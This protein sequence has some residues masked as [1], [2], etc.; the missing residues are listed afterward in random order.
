MTF[1]VRLCQIINDHNSNVAEFARGI[2]VWRRSIHRWL[3]GTQEPNARYLRRIVEFWP[4]VD[5]HWLIT[6]EERSM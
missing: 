2:R 5:L 6:G 1:N 3:N 4:D